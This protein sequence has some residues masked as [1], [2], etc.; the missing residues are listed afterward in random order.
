MLGTL[1]HPAAFGY[2]MI[3]GLGVGINWL[4][5]GLMRDAINQ[6]RLP[7]GFMVY[8][9]NF[10]E[11]KR[12]NKLRDDEEYEMSLRGVLHTKRVFHTIWDNQF[13]KYFIPNW[14]NFYWLKC[15]KKNKLRY[16]NKAYTFF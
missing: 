13:I 8:F 3:A 4:K 9:P 11:E 10:N 16:K 6:T 5:L 14:R 1:Y 7:K 15:I 2:G 12:M